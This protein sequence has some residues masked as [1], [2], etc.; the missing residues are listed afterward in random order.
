M[1]KK[2]T[3]KIGRYIEF[4]HEDGI[5]ENMLLLTEKEANALEKQLKELYKKEEQLERLNN[6]INKAMECIKEYKEIIE[7]AKIN[8]NS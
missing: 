6:I 8:V 7:S 5:C 3:V 2:E 4:E 1:S